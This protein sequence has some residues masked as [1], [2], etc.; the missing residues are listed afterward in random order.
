MKHKD[1]GISYLASQL[2]KFLSEKSKLTVEYRQTGVTHKRPQQC[3]KQEAM[4][5]TSQ[6]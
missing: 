3:F 5:Q 2:G 1:N 4:F 6:H